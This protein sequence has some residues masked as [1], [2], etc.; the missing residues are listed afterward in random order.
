V[1]SSFSSPSLPNGVTIAVRM[2][3]ITAGAA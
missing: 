3:P 2:P 1:A